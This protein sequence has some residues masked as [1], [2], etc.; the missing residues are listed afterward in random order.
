MNET[1]KSTEG[2]TLLKQA[3][4]A[5]QEMQAKLEAA[6]LR[7]REPIAVVGLGCRFPGGADSGDS[8][9]DLLRDGRD[10]ISLVPPDRWDADAYYDPDPD[11][12][13]KMVTRWGGFLDQVDQFDT[14]FFEI[15]P[16]EAASMDPQQRLALEVAW[17]TLENAGIAPMDLRATKT[18]I[19]LGIA[20]NDYSQLHAQTGDPAAMDAHY[21]SGI[22]HS[23]ASGRISYLL[24]L[25][26]PSISLD[27]ACSSSLV[28]VHLACESLRAG[29]CSLALAGGVNAMLAPETTAMLSRVRMLSPDGR[30]KAFDESADGFVRGEGCGFVAL[31]T[32]SQAQSDGNRILAVIR[33]T[34]L[35]QDG[36]SSS[37]TAPHGPSQVKL[38]RQAL[39]AA[40]IAPSDVSYIEAHGTGTALGDPIELQALGAVYG[41]GRPKPLYVG[42]LKTNIGHLEAA[43]GVAGLIKTILALN[44]RQI[45]AHLHLKQ[46]TSHVRWDE[47]KLTVPRTLTDWDTDGKERIAAVS[48]FGFSGTNAHIVVAEALPADAP[49]GES[50]WPT[51]MLALSAKSH[52]SLKRLTELYREVL[53]QAPAVDLRD[54]CY[55]ANT[56]RSHFPHRA[57]FLAADAEQLKQQ[58]AA[59]ESPAA[60]VTEVE[61]ICFL[62]TGQG[63]QYVGM[64]RELYEGSTVFRAAIDRCAAAWKEETGESLI[65]VLYPRE[66]EVGQAESRMKRAR[67]A[68]P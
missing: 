30:C 10:A 54:V 59:F 14:K 1:K 61:G 41:A 40:G 45:P 39:A 20:S 55:T 58:L 34:A 3:F 32:L 22:A 56:G 5:V 9:W 63:S 57:C 7:A 33:G 65:E 68:Q 13:G 67:Y 36:A 24:G 8:F 42:S 6:E 16:R 27:T 17:E 18:G 66:D 35:N 4:L 38:M 49:R 44:H 60:P 47:L 62:C 28:A 46:L 53:E 12:P 25:E 21:A 23:I 51:Q 11:Q 2:S 26:G 19:F 64:G 15:A 43:A 48:S 29:D 50:D 37:M 31:K 52:T